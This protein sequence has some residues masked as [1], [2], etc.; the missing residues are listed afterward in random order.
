MAAPMFLHKN[1][2]RPWLKSLQTTHR[3]LAPT[4]EDN[5]ILFRPLSESKDIELTHLP[6]TSPKEAVFPAC[7]TLMHYS[8]IK[9]AEHPDRTVLKID[10]DL[11]GPS[12]LPTLVF[13]VRP[14]DVRGLEVFDKVYA[15]GK[16]PD[17]YYVKRRENTV[18]A[19]LACVNPASGCF[20][21]WTGGDPANT[22][23]ADY[24]F[25]PV[26]NGFVV[27]VLTDRAGDLMGKGFFEKSSKQ[28]IAE[29]ASAKDAART[30]LGN[31]PELA[32]M[33]II[34]AG[35]FDDLDFWNE[36]SAQCVSCGACAYLCPSCYC[37]SITDEARGNQ[38]KR[39][40]T[41]DNCMSYNFT[42]EGSGHNP[43]PT[44]AHRYRNRV[45]HK[46]AY[47]PEIHG[48][49]ACV[50]C[51]RCIRSCPAS[52]DIR[53]VLHKA[54]KRAAAPAKEAIND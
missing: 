9:D 42:L 11:P 31:T 40:R 36:A 2:L 25:T 17:A 32:D 38:G 14:C 8:Y 24:L 50:G 48:E 39:I 6:T 3:V 10:E 29:A 16:R 22:A 12:S 53:D 30:A 51:G 35:L 28:H 46:F 44:K 21:N 13:G 37:F 26:E 20:C 1:Q 47:Y 23:G 52:M 19:A 34:L 54:R 7:E 4:H 5:A 41:W 49:F 18:L 33:P 43:R 45:G 27:D 15:A